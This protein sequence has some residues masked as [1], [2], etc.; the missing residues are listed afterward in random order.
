MKIAWAFLAACIGS[1]VAVAGIAWIAVMIWQ[2]FTLRQMLG[3][4]LVVLL[5]ATAAHAG[6]ATRRRPTQ[7]KRRPF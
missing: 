1:W 4:L 2:T 6:G 3:W 7:T 5:A